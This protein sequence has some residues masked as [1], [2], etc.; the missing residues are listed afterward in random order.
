MREGTGWRFECRDCGCSQTLPTEEARP[1]CVRCG[2]V[3]MR[4]E[5]VDGAEFAGRLAAE[6]SYEKKVKEEVEVVWSLQT[7]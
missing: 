6:S 7:A 1:A 4:S 2:S 3:D 5:S